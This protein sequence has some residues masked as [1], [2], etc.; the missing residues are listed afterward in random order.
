TWKDG[1][2]SKFSLLE[3]RKNCP[4]V[5]C[6]GGHGGKIGSTTG[7]INQIQILS[8]KKVGRYALNIVWSDYHDTGIYTYD[9]LRN[10][11]EKGIPF[12]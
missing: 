5:T 8:W 7:H 2:N 1:F 3:L 12:E 10:L 9:S 4:C 6:R 11:S